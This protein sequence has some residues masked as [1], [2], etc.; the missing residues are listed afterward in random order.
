MSIP[1]FFSCPSSLSP[2]QLAFKNW[3][4]ER[5]GELGL[6]ARTVGQTMSDYPV[7]LPLREVRVLGRHCSGAVI[8]G[9]E[10]FRT[11]GAVLKPGSEHERQE[12]REFRFPTP[13]NHLEAG[14]LFGLGLPMVVI[15]EFGVEG[16]IFDIGASDVFVHE[17]KLR[18]PQDQL[19]GRLNSVLLRWQAQ[20]REH[21][22]RD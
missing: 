1:V 16:G 13:W 7:E 6:E 19:R 2:D 14:I 5:F 8:L 20:V 17:M 12:S 21:Y 9:A 4:L 15:K 18:E 11:T 10:Q 3:L 22:Y